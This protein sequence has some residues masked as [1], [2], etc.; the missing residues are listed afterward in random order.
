M[1]LMK[2]SLVLLAGVTFASGAMAAAKNAKGGRKVTLFTI[3]CP[4][5]SELERDNKEEVAVTTFTKA[6]KVAWAG[7]FTVPEHTADFDPVPTT[8]HLAV[9]EKLATGPDDAKYE[10]PAAYTLTCTYD[11]GKNFSKG[12]MK[13]TYPTDML[14]YGCWQEKGHDSSIACQ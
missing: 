7:T 14:G 8:S 5:A 3:T 2:L 6:G 12:T 4:T 13:Y 11:A 10:M 9:A 1:N